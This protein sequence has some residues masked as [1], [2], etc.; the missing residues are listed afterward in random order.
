MLY[1]LKIQIKKAQGGR[2]GFDMGGA[3]SIVLNPDERERGPIFETD[4]VEDA[5]REII[6]RGIRIEGAQIPIS[7]KGQLGV[8]IPRLDTIGAGGLLN[9]LGGELEVGGMKDFGSGR[10]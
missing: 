9:L 5:I 3:P 10:E 7:E 4:K 1:H 6:K 8:A 2:A